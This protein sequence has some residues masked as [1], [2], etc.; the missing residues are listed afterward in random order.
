MNDWAKLQGSE[1][2]RATAVPA[3]AGPPRGVKE[4]R[5]ERPQTCR[6]C[7]E[8]RR[9]GRAPERRPLEQRRGRCGAGKLQ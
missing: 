9:R 8:T 1:W 2:W 5:R 3:E 7:A 4:S 6:W